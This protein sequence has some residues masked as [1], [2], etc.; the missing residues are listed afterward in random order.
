MSAVINQLARYHTEVLSPGE[1]RFQTGSW[2]SSFAALPGQ[3]H[4]VVLTFALV[5]DHYIVSGGTLAQ[6]IML[7]SSF[8]MPYDSATSSKPSLLVR[9]Q[10]DHVGNILTEVEHQSQTA[11]QAAVEGIRTIAKLTHEEIAPLAGVSR[12][13]IQA[14]LAGEPIS[15]RK[16]QR[17]RAVLDAI[18]ELA[19]SDPQTTRGRLFDRQRGQISAYDLLAEGRFEDAKAL[20]LGHQRNVSG[21][22]IPQ[23]QNLYAQLDRHEGRVELPAE[24]LNRRFSGRLRR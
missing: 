12:R 23:A 17:L 21:Q 7:G 22:A 2:T 19:A 9:G 1:D 10:N 4:F 14:W 6:C 18:R 8:R 16:E 5:G 13:S 3:D 11:A 15:A 24:P 20:V